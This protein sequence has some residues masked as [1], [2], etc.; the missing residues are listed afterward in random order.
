MGK[1]LWRFANDWGNGIAVDNQGN[2]LV[3]GEYHSTSMTFGS[4]TLTLPF[5]TWGPNLCLLKLDLNG[6]PLW[7]RK[8]G[9]RQGR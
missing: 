8:C 2:V 7:A 4:T 3:S 9:R 1:I 5:T 6:N